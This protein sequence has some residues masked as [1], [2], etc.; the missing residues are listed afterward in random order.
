M[1]EQPKPV[2]YMHK[3][4]NGKTAFTA[5][6][7]PP[8]GFD[9][10]NAVITPLY[11][12]SQVESSDSDLLTRL[13]DLIRKYEGGATLNL[14]TGFGSDYI[15]LSAPGTSLREKLIA[16]LEIKPTISELSL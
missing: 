3:W 14:D 8:G 13:E 6:E 4:P 1:S 10:W 2:A 9:G 12:E 5:T 15:W 11:A 16:L 7:K